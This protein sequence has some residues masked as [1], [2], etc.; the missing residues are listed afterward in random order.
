MKTAQDG[1]KYVSLT[2]LPPYPRQIH[3][4]IISVR[5]WVDPRENL[6]VFIS[7]FLLKH[8]RFYS[9]IY[10]YDCWIKYRCIYIYIRTSILSTV[11]G[12][13]YTTVNEPIQ[14]NTAVNN[15]SWLQWTALE[16]RL[17]KT[18]T[19]FYSSEV[20]RPF[21]SQVQFVSCG[22]FLCAFSESVEGIWR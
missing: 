14:Q 2:Q 15:N 10:R 4:V 11:N 6:F 7:C 19:L 21:R 13:V 1:G 5:A 9:Q 3:L 17:Q 12:S 18:V 22:W 20:R 16:L 8:S